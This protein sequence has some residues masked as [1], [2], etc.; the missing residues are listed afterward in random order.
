MVH[1]TGRMLK[2]Q[3][4]FAAVE[5]QPVGIVHPG[6]TRAEVKLRAV[7]LVVHRRIVHRDSTTDVTAGPQLD[8]LTGGSR[9][10]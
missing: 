6:M 1:E 9:R 2:E 4:V 5:N 8:W 10:R 7:Q 3:V